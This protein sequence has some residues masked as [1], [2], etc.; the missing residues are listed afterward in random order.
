MC[1]MSGVTF[2]VSTV[3][4]NLPPVICHLSLTPTATAISPPPS[5]SPIMH[6]RLVLKDAK[7]Y[8]YF[9]HGVTYVTD[10]VCISVSGEVSRRRV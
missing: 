3:T 8:L 10:G 4:C 5:N 9:D 6:S 7:I 1:H 2:H